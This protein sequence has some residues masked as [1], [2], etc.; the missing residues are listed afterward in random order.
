MSACLHI[1]IVSTNTQPI[2][3]KY[4]P[5]RTKATWTATLLGMQSDDL[6][7]KPRASRTTCQEDG[8]RMG[9]IKSG[10]TQTHTRVNLQVGEISKVSR[11]SCAWASSHVGRQTDDSVVVKAEYDTSL[12]LSSA[13]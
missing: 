12:A 11:Q 2:Q 8:T 1:Y 10:K 6:R 13:T 7:S 3:S 4:P 9:V 5:K